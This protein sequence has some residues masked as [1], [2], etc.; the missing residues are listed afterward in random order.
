MP[1]CFART[2][3]YYCCTLPV[4]YQQRISIIIIMPLVK[5]YAKHAM[6]KPIPLMTLQRKLCNIWRTEPSTTKLILSRVEDWTDA[7]Y[8][9]DCYVDIRA[10]GKEGTCCFVIVLSL[11]L[12]SIGFP[13]INPPSPLW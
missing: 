1:S 3:H 13:S 2:R 10:Y 6:T 7:S 12:S 8:Q 5:I 11:C 4:V 9:E